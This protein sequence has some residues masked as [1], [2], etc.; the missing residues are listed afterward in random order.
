MYKV[1]QCDMLIFTE[2]KVAT[3]EPCDFCC[4][5]LPQLR[6]LQLNSVR[7]A[8]GGSLAARWPFAKPANCA[9]RDCRASAQPD[10]GEFN[11]LIRNIM[12]LGSKQEIGRWLRALERYLPNVSLPAFPVALVFVQGA[13]VHS[14]CTHDIWRGKY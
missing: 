10:C 11:T 3:E 5:D 14:W 8:L 7:S 13:D 6:H 2:T 1:L 4:P 9:A 12:F